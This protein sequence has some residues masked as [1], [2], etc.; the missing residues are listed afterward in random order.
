[1]HDNPGAARLPETLR[2]NIG[3]IMNLRNAVLVAL[4]P[5]GLSGVVAGQN[6]TG[7][8]QWRGPS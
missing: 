3:G 7:D 5:P 4:S 8:P 2:Q 6:A 1:L